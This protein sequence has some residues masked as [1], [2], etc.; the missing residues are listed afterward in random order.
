MRVSS[1]ASD[2][3]R[4]LQHKEMLETMKGSGKEEGGGEEWKQNTSIIHNFFLHAKKSNT[5]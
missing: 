2:V 4:S 3:N 5:I 1:N